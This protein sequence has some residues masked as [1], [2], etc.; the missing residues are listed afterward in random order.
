[1]ESDA[2]TLNILVVDDSNVTHL[3]LSTFLRTKKHKA[4]IFSA[5]DGK[6]AIAQL[7]KSQKYDFIIMDIDMPVMDGIKAT[8]IIK[9]KW[10]MIPVILHSCSD[11]PELFDN[12]KSFGFSDILQKPFNANCFRNILEKYGS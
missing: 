9:K 7:K 5:H 12:Y 2:K 8:E 4:Y 11:Q 1:M 3:L 10:P 6:E